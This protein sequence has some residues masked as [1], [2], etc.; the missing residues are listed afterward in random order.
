MVEQALGEIKERLAL[1]GYTL[2]ATESHGEIQI[3][4]EAGP[5]ACAECLSPK[6]IL[7]RMI[8]SELEQKGV[9]YH[10]I[11]IIMPE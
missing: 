11:N 6:P 2:S 5:N 7:E 4:I 10:K 9:N 8:A 3:I 1:D